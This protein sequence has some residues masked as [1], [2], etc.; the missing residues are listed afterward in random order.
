[1]SE[2]SITSILGDNPYLI[3]IL[4]KQPSM[5]TKFNSY[6]SSF[7]GRSNGFKDMSEVI[8][9]KRLPNCFLFEKV[10]TEIIHAKVTAATIM[11]NS[12]ICGTSEGQIV[13]LK[14]REDFNDREDH[15]T[16]ISHPKESL[17]S[18]HH[19]SSVTAICPGSKPESLWVAFSDGTLKRVTISLALS[20]DFSANIGGLDQ[21]LFVTSLVRNGEILFCGMSM[22]LIT[23]FHETSARQITMLQGPATNITS[24]FVS[25]DILFATHSCGLMDSIEGSNSLQPWD[26]SDILTCGARKL[27]QWGPVTSSCIGGASLSRTCNRI[28]VFSSNGV[29]HVL[30]RFDDPP[31]IVSEF[32]LD[33]D[34]ISSLDRNCLV[35][36][37]DGIFV[38]SENCVKFFS[39][40]ASDNAELFKDI[41]YLDVCESIQVEKEGRVV[42]EEV[43]DPPMQEYVASD[44]DDDDLRSWARE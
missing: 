27:P 4:G 38:A 9:W 28:V 32:I 8:I 10:R 34:P 12:L 23:V 30:N 44:S 39:I 1:M 11:G 13:I 16:H 5:M 40:P 42:D 2:M 41:S 6:I 22:G 15:E 37:D 7:L 24:L 25:N 21:G 19:F 18:I 20:S 29:V 35:T 3:T 33:T 36:M 14:L 43:P 31:A 17:V 26:V